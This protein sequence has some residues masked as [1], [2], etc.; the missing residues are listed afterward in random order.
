MPQARKSARSSSRTSTS[1]KEPAAL[2]RL[3]RSLDSAQKA[4]DDL[5]GQAGRNATASTRAL[6]KGLGKF[7]SSAR[8]DT[9]KFTTAIKRDFEQAQKAAKS[10]QRSATTATSRRRSTGRTTAT[11]RT[12]KK[13]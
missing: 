6:H 10:A 12:R 9:G 2:K 5:R 3:N 8:R 7:L 11:R 1:F 4:L 13:S